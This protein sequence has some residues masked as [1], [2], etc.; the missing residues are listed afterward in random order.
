MAEE[1]SNNIHN[2]G[3]KSEYQECKSEEAHHASQKNCQQKMTDTHFCH[4]G[5]QCKNFE[6]SWRRQHCGKH[7]APEGMLLER[8]VHFVEA[9]FGHALPQQFLT[10]FI[11]NCVDHQTTDC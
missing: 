10:A 2:S 9:L 8:I 1:G 6:R 11:S 4:G 7:Q 5:P 3:T